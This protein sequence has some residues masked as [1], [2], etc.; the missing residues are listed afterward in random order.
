MASECRHACRLFA[1][2]AVV[3]ER[4][5]AREPPRAQALMQPA[6]RHAPRHATARVQTMLNAV[7]PAKQ[8]P[9]LTRTA[10]ARFASG[11][12]S[13]RRCAHEQQVV[14]SCAASTPATGARRQHTR[15]GINV[16]QM[17]LNRPQTRRPPALSPASNSTDGMA[18]CRTHSSHAF[19]HARPTRASMRHVI[20]AGTRRC[21]H[22]VTAQR[23]NAPETTPNRV[24]QSVKQA[25][26]LRH[27]TRRHDRG[28]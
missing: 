22:E 17:M 27:K 16:A 7:R 5:A 13:R 4:Y 24:K 10:S 15:A 6:R 19:C 9:R 2:T 14:V 1:Y 21:R 26:L 28:C 25:P 3:R 12:M 23:Y 20:A 18:C 11:M 8:A